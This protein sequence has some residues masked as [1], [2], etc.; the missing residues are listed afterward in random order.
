MQNMK[1]KNDKVQEK[2]YIW[3]NIENPE[4]NHLEN[5]F[6]FS[7]EESVRRESFSSRI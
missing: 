4:T 1:H 7:I 6:S 2:T 5:S 3:L